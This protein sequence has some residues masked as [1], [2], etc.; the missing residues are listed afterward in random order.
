MRAA[1]QLIEPFLNP[2]A[3][4]RGIF[5]VAKHLANNETCKLVTTSQSGL[6]QSLGLEVNEVHFCIPRS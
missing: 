3:D 2:K 5:N 6:L 1:K 4:P